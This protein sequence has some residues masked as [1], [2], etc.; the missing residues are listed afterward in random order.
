MGLLWTPLQQNSNDLNA[1]LMRYQICFNLALISCLGTGG[2]TQM[3]QSFSF[4]WEFPVDFKHIKF[5]PQTEGS[6]RVLVEP[7]AW[8]LKIFTTMSLIWRWEAVKMCLHIYNS[9]NCNILLHFWIILWYHN[10]K[11]QQYNAIWEIYP[12]ICVCMWLISQTVIF[13]SKTAISTQVQRK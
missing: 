3:Q 9:P 11:M 8:D 1:N 4:N 5:K 12:N 2:W 6:A 10:T 7:V 13:R